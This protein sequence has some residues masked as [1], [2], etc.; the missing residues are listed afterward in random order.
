MYEVCMKE[1][2]TRSNM[3]CM[4]DLQ[5][6]NRPDNNTTVENQEH[7]VKE[8]IKL[9][10]KT[11]NEIVNIIQLI[12]GKVMKRKITVSNDDDGQRTIESLRLESIKLS[13]ELRSTFAPLNIKKIVKPIVV[14]QN[15]IETVIFHNLEQGQDVTINYKQHSSQALASSHENLLSRILRPDRAPTQRN[16]NSKIAEPLSIASFKKLFKN[17]KQIL[18]SRLDEW[19]E[20]FVAFGDYIED[21]RVNTGRFQPLIKDI[22]TKLVEYYALGGTRVSPF[23]SFENITFSPIQPIHQILELITYGPLLIDSLLS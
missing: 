11:L 8:A 14:S 5:V 15:I 10:M 9:N 2:L 4:Q 21:S 3:Q 1:I 23:I 19:T 16:I 17:K 18:R 12:P 20:V 22:L 6:F 13:A 7:K